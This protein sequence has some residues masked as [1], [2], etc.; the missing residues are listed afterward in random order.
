M[1]YD[2]SKNKSLGSFIAGALTALIGAGYFLFGSRHAR[3]NRRKVEGWFE[4]ARSEV[5]GKIRNTK[6][7]SRDKYNQIVDTVSDKYSQMKDV[8]RDKAD[9]FR[10]ELRS[11]W[12][13]MEKETRDRDEDIE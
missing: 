11:Y 3:R 2:N 10:D 13:D 7:L 12:E 9:E 6:R 8:G 4:D 5:M 1:H